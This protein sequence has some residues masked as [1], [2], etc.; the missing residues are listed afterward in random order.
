VSEDPRIERT[1]K[2]IEKSLDGILARPLMWGPPEG[3]ECTFL[4]LLEV[5]HGIQHVDCKERCAWNCVVNYAENVLN[6]NSMLWSRIKD[7]KP[8][9]KAIHVLTE[10]LSA[11][12]QNYDREH[13]IPWRYVFKDGVVWTEDKSVPPEN[14]GAIQISTVKEERI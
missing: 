8:E 11:I 4:T 12:R 6:T 9:R 2:Y 3:L 7:L 1:L 10:H 5:K 13:P 14:H